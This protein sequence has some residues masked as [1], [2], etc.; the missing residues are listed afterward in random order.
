ME[1]MSREEKSYSCIAVLGL[2]SLG[3]FVTETVSDLEATKKIILVDY[4]RVEERNLKNTIYRPR[5][6]G[7]LKTDVLADIIQS[8]GEGDIEIVKLNVEFEEFKIELPESD[9]VLDCRDFTYNRKDLID[10]RLYI[11]A[12]Y[13]I[14]DCRKN[15]LYQKHY[16]G[17]YTSILTKSDLK[18]ASFIASA[19]ICNNIISSLIKDKTVSKFDLDYLKQMRQ[20]TNDVI[21]GYEAGEERLVNLKD[22]LL[23]IIEFNKRT[24]L[25]V[26]VC[27]GD[28]I[29]SMK[30]IP[31]DTLRSGNDVIV[32]LTSMINLPF[33]FSNYIVSL[34]KKNGGKS[35]LLIPETGAA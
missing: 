28:R 32:N 10:A 15:V 6:V 16:E 30:T 7:R 24:D 27:I 35:I 26:N 33:T 25:D 3:G 8:K 4:D 18:N 17:R 5:D 14:V 11:S 13:L 20:K 21:Y 1:N 29:V 34:D 2:G 12:R 23:P 9:L 22:N 31:R 19:L